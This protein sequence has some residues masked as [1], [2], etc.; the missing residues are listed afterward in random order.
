MTLD[1]E[2]I[3]HQEASSVVDYCHLSMHCAVISPVSQYCFHSLLTNDMRYFGHKCQYAHSKRRQ[4]FS[5]V[6]I[7]IAT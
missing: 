5:V 1:L 6:I 2:L 3:Q 4:L 7:E